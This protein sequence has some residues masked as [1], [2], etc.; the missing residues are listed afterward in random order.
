MKRSQVFEVRREG[1]TEVFVFPHKG[2]QKGPGARQ[3]EPFYN[4]AMELNRDLSVLMNQWFVTQMRK[5]VHLLDGLAASG[6][7]GVRWAK[8]IK[9]DFDVTINDWD[10]QA[11]TLI[12][13]NIQ[14]NNLTNACASKKDVNVLLAEH[15]YHSI[16]IDPF[17]S[18]V[19]FVDAAFRSVYHNGLVACTAT[20]TATLCGV[21]PKVCLRR[22][23]AYPFRSPI[24]HEVGV[25]ILLGFLCRE[26][27]KYDKG[28]E[29]L[30]SH[31]TDH[32]FRVY[33]Q[34]RKGKDYANQS[35]DELMCINAKRIKEFSGGYSPKSAIGP[36]WMG[37]L[38]KREV[39]EELRTSLFDRQFNTKHDLWRLLSFFEEEA[40][41]PPFFYTT[42]GIASRFK[43]PLPTMDK[44]F[45]EIQTRG[46]RVTRT[47]FHPTGF[48]TTAP[49]DE[50]KEV[51]K[52]RTT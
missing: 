44:L 34:V 33:V 13:K 19:P 21:Y 29:P 51:F 32:Y 35:I 43:H 49:F 30:I 16:D 24:M 15:R 26:A 6:V 11:C 1:T 50:V 5:Q 52:G 31:S 9:G 46:Y 17:G 4:P 38:H 8:E 7:R 18:P 12:E 40:D 48:K 2:S 28:I 42:E 41:A 22:Y 25:R 39:V 3:K 37:N 36:L 47:H 23:G 45:E 20:D 14:Y 10:T 27:A